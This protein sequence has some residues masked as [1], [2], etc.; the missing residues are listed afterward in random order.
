MADGQPRVRRILHTH[1]QLL[2]VVNKIDIVHVAILGSDEKRRDQ[3]P[4]AT[5]SR[6]QN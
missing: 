5:E 1:G 2:M 3:M 4:A 6:G